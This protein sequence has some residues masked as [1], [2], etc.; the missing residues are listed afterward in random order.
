MW[1]DPK[2]ETPKA[3]RVDVEAQSDFFLGGSRWTVSS[4]QKMYNDRCGGYWMSNHMC[5][6]FLHQG[7][8]TVD[9]LSPVSDKTRPAEVC[10]SLFG[11][12]KTVE[13]LL[14]GPGGYTG[15]DVQ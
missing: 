6:Y 4:S 10:E 13:K 5:T 9:L 12:L 7:Q 15:L 11:L 1:E 3:T 2:I 8:K 14:Q